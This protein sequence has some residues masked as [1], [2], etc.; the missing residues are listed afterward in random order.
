MRESRNAQA[1]IFDFCSDHDLG[2]RLKALS[3]VLDDSPDILSVLARDFTREDVSHTGARGLSLESI[4]RCL[5]LKLTLGVSYRT[6]E[7][8]LSDSPT[9][10]WFARLRGSQSPSRSTLQATM[11]RVSPQTLQTINQQL[12]SQWVNEGEVSLEALRIDS[13]VVQSTIA[14]PSDS[15]LLTD[16]VRVL[17]RLMSCSKTRTGVKVRFVDQ[18]KRSKSLAFRIFHAKKA[19]KDLLY[20][21][22]LSSVATT[23]RQTDKA[24]NKVRCDALV[25][26][27]VQR[28]LEEVEHYRGLLLKVIDQT[29]R[30]VFDEQT[31]PVSEKV[32][33]L[34]ESHTD[35]IVKGK[36]E[37]RYGHK[38]NLATQGEGFVTYLNI[39]QGNP[40]DKTLYMPVLKACH[41]DYG[42]PPIDVVADGGYASQA[43]VTVA[44][45]SGVKRVVFNKRVGLTYHQM[46]VKKKT[47]ERLKNFRAG[48]EGNISELK[49][50]FGMG[51]ANWKGHEG[52]KAYVWSAVLSYNLSRMARFSSA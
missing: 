30:R 35:I 43:N 20:P 50:A 4:F 23:L 49:R 39:E 27:Q 29:Q 2:Q 1:S 42:Q 48:I 28:W 24:L 26:A 3:D 51:R 40:A 5:I 15:Q 37:V 34:F 41:S 25:C 32:V 18:R 44:R 8:V 14:P 52:F 12:M 17:S 13:T 46:G 9:Y 6:L 7:F 31:V 16:G 38:V 36:R 21:Q 47:F 11:R 22:L 45:A 33:S 19:E 10:R